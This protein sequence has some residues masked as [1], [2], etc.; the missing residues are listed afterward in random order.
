MKLSDYIQTF[1]RNQRKGIRQKIAQAAGVTE[2]AVRHW[3]K[4]VRR[5]PSERMRAIENATE[6]VVTCY[7]MLP[8]A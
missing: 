8:D 6:G 5:I 1:P 7:D 2:P 4:G 3:C